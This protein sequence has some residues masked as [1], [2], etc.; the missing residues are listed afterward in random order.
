MTDLNIT[1]FLI[2]VDGTHSMSITL[3]QRIFVVSLRNWYQNLH[4]YRI[5]ISSFCDSVRS[6]RK[7]WDT[8]REQT[9]LAERFCP[10]LELSQLECESCEGRPRMPDFRIAGSP[11][12]KIHKNE[13]CSRDRVLS[14]QPCPTGRFRLEVYQTR[15]QSSG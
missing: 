2:F 11:K 1:F 7:S 14:N 13:S 6:N 12:S 8:S 3:Q 15:S 10:E 5:R 4:K 9:T